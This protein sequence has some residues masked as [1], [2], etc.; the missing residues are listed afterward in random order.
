MAWLEWMQ[1]S[2]GD[3]TI[4]SGAHQMLGTKLQL[5]LAA[6]AGYAPDLQLENG[7]DVPKSQFNPYDYKEILEPCCNG[8]REFDV[9]LEG[10]FND[11]LER[12]GV[13]LPAGAATGPLAAL[14]A[15]AEKKAWL[16]KLLM[17]IPADPTENSDSIEQFARKHGGL[18]GEIARVRAVADRL[19]RWTSRPETL[20]VAGPTIEKAK[21]IQP[22]I[23][24]VTAAVA[25][26]SVSDPHAERAGIAADY[27]R[28]WGEV[29]GKGKLIVKGEGARSSADRG[30]A[31]AEFVGTGFQHLLR[32][33]ANRVR[34]LTYVLNDVTTAVEGIARL[35]GAPP[36]RSSLAL[37]GKDGVSLISPKR[38]FGYAA[39]GFHFVTSKP[40]KSV[41][42]GLEAL[43]D[44]VQDL[45][46]TLRAPAADPVPGFH[47]RSQ[48]NV[49]F[50][51]QG[52]IN[53]WA[54]GPQSRARVTSAFAAELSAMRAVGISARMGTA[55]VL[56]KSVVIGSTAG[57]MKATAA[58]V[59]AGA[60]S[61]AADAAADTCVN[62]INKNEKELS[63]TVEKH[64]RLLLNE[65][66]LTLRFT[67]PAKFAKAK[68]LD[69]AGDALFVTVQADRAALK[70]LQAAQTVAYKAYQAA[71]DAAPLK[72]PLATAMDWDGKQVQAIAEKIEM[73]SAETVDVFSKDVSVGSTG[74]IKL[75]SEPPLPGLPGKGTVTV[76]S[77]QVEINVGDKFKVVVS[78]SS[79]SI[80]AM[81]QTVLKTDGVTATLELGG[82]SVKLTATG[83]DLAG[84]MTNV[85]G[86][87]INLG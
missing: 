70:G 17:G 46:A 36:P 73:A 30:T 21:A 62:R 23:Q 61:E 42:T 78:E 22:A 20:P 54:V 84:A 40:V 57:R 4:M 7:L 19:E 3:M 14:A 45:G 65:D 44:K 86:E 34:A 52:D 55:E 48:G 59:M 79:V 64:R 16:L 47:V 41:P 32:P 87:M 15:A 83:L 38:V 35:F 8:V 85:M 33:L 31:A 11:F 10:A 75:Q 24:G 49:D 51:S 81:G 63:E 76:T 58:V 68:A 6:G 2:G 72:S 50:R 77:N 66:D 28:E 60:A 5:I 27:G 74:T 39:D 13:T 43:L 9:D 25:A 12:S 80:Q 26:L 71:L 69:A 56:G 1:S 18:L 29:V 37:V 53:L 67:N 82:S